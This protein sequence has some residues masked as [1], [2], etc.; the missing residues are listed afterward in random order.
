[1]DT[2][3]SLSLLLHTNT[4]EDIRLPENFIKGSIGR[5]LGGFLEGFLGRFKKLE[6]GGFHFNNIITNYQDISEAIEME[7]VANR[8]GII[9]TVLLSRFNIIIDYPR[10]KL[11]MQPHRKYNKGFKYDRSGLEL[12][13]S[14]KKLNTVTVFNVIENSPAFKAGI[15]RGDQLIS[16][17]YLPAKLLSLK[18]VTQRMTK[19]EGKKI[20]LKIIRGGKKMVFTFRLK[21]LI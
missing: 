19:K 1:M 2:G 8:N 9:G 7:I 17:N 3:A 11:Y 21:D 14:G 6:F 18:G 15:E 16:I 20:R 13:I 10:G 4:N 12:I 5:G